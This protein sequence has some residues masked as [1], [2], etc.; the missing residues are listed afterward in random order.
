[1]KFKILFFAIALFFGFNQVSAQDCSRSLSFFAESAKVKNYDEAMT[2]YNTLIENCKDASIAIYQRGAIMFKDLLDE[3]QDP[4]QKKIIAKR[5]IANNNARLEYFPE[6]TDIGSIKADN[7]MI[8]YETKIGSVQDQFDLFDEAWTK[9]QENFTNPKAIYEY[10]LLMVNLL[11]NEK[12]S[13]Q[14]VFEKYDEILLHLE[15][16]ENKQAKVA[17]PLIEKQEADE[18]ISKKQKRILRNAELRLKNYDLIRGAVNGVIG[19][20]AECDNLIPLFEKDFE[21][22]KG[23]IEWV[24]RAA[25]RLFSKECTDSEL[26]VKLVEQQHKLEPSAK[27]A[28]YIGRLAERSGDFNKAL[29]YYKQSAELE[30]KA[31]DKAK[32]YYN[33]ANSYKAKNSYSNARTYYRKALEFQ[34]SMGRAYLKIAEMYANSANNCGADVFEKQSVYWLAADYAERAGRVSPGLKENASQ[35][36]KSYRGRAPQTKDVFQSG[37]QGQKIKFDSC[38]IGESVTVPTI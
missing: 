35:T 12:V 19:S 38:W 26:F 16:L 15:N 1:M 34:P 18:E 24:K 27:S 3:E 8:M 28:L 30:T 32:V 2:H 14:S 22:N 36:A 4:E 5:L 25:G 17:A 23:D 31:T 21:T 33:I 20:R 6:K 13:L 11:D 9:D 37:R 29:E 10:F 7:A